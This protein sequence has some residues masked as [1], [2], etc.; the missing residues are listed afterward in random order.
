MGNHFTSRI[1]SNKD[2]KIW[3]NDGNTTRGKRIKVSQLFRKRTHTCHA[4]A[5]AHSKQV[6]EGQFFLIES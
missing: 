3:F 5:M 2:G 4:I 1:I 6:W